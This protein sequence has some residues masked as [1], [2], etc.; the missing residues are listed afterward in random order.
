MKRRSGETRFN[1]VPLKG[2]PK[3]KKKGAIMKDGADVSLKATSIDDFNDLVY[4]RKIA[5]IVLIAFQ[6][7]FWSGAAILVSKVV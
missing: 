4:G 2:L 1:I 7:I 5:I 6:G 3:E